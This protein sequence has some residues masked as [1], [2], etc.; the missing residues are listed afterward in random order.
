VCPF[1]H[2]A[3][4]CIILSQLSQRKI[5]FR[6]SW[7]NQGVENLPQVEKAFTQF[8]KPYSDNMHTMHFQQKKSAAL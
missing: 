4:G 3:F 5:P 7:T 1:G 2:R 8:G 6:P